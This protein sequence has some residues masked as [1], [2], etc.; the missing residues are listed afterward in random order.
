MANEN[1]NEIVEEN[2][3]E[4]LMAVEFQQRN[5]KHQIQMIL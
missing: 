5:L 3:T 2:Q 1:Q 4:G